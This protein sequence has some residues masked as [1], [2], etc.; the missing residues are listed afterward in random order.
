MKATQEHEPGMALRGAGVTSEAEG[1]TEPAPT[2][3]RKPSPFGTSRALMVA[4]YCDECRRAE[5]QRATS[6][7]SERPE[8]RGNAAGR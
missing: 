5:E 7:Q 6:E 4:R 8:T 1:T 3:R 2:W